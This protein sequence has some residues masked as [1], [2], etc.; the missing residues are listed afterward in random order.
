MGGPRVLDITYSGLF[1]FML[2]N[3]IPAV[4]AWAQNNNLKYIKSLLN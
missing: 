1:D 4:V 3:E 2:V